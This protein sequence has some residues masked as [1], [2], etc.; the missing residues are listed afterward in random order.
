VVKIA[1]E[2]EQ[3]GLLTSS[4]AE[5]D[6]RKRLLTLS[7]K[8]LQLLPQLQPLWGAI[9]QVTQDLLSQQQHNL[10]FAVEEMETGSG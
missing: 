9:S 1:G 4:K 5:S 3:H 6:S 7:E 8:G 2:I 10:L